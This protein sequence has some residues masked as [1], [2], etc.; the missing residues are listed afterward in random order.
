[1]WR[2]IASR[3]AWGLA[4][5]VLLGSIPS[6]QGDEHEAGNADEAGFRRALA[7]WEGLG[8]PDLTGRPIVRLALRQFEAPPEGTDHVHRPRPRVEREFGFLLS[9]DDAEIRVLNFD[10]R[11]RTYPLA[12]FTDLEPIAL[13]TREP[14]VAWK[15]FRERWEVEWIAWDATTLYPQ[16]WYDPFKSDPIP[17]TVAFLMAHACSLEGDTQGALNLWR[18]NV[19]RLPHRNPEDDWTALARLRDEVLRLALD[20]WSESVARRSASW[21]SALTDLRMLKG[22]HGH[23][24]ARAP[25][26]VARVAE[27]ETTL[28]GMALEESTY[29]A[30]LA[31]ASPAPAQRA[32]RLLKAAPAGLWLR[33]DGT[34]AHWAP[35]HLEMG[36]GPGYRRED[37]PRIFR[38]LLDLGPPAYPALLAHLEDERIVRC[39]MQEDDDD[40]RYEDEPFEWRL[41]RVWELALAVLEASTGRHFEAYAE[42]GETAHDAVLRWW[43]LYQ[44]EG[45]RGVLIAGV[46]DAKR[47]SRH[48]AERL[49]ERYPEVALA[50]IRQVCAEKSPWVPRPYV[51]ALRVSRDPQA[52]A[53]LMEVVRTA[54]WG[55]RIAACRVLEARG[56]P[57]VWH[58]LLVD[59]PKIAGSNYWEQLEGGSSGGIEESFVYDLLIYA[60]GPLCLRARQMLP[61]TSAELQWALVDGAPL[62]MGYET[63]APHEQAPDHERS[64]VERDAIEAMLIAMIEAHDGTGR[65]AIRAAE[66]LAG[67]WPD[68]YEFDSRTARV[69]MREQAYE[70]VN[71]WRFENDRDELEVPSRPGY[72]DIAPAVAF[73]ILEAYVAADPGAMR[74]RLQAL[75]VEL[76]FDMLP[77]IHRQRRRSHTADQ[78]IG[79]L[80]ELATEVAS[81]VRELRWRE[82]APPP[83]DAVR[84][85]AAALVGKPVSGDGLMAIFR[86]FARGHDPSHAGVRCTLIREAEE[87][88]YVLELEMMPDELELPD[89]HDG[90][91][92]TTDSRVYLPESLIEDQLGDPESWWTRFRVRE[93]EHELLRRP[94][95][96]AVRFVC[97]LVR[98]KQG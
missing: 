76:G 16:R 51:R 85:R 80:D 41:D 70:I 71:A 74:K 10:L 25:S 1:M 47:I 54:A 44:A 48:R 72:I 18:E 86:A 24:L 67:F 31:D 89:K 33:Y 20:A 42:E 90:Y 60:P 12:Q 75:I 83:P 68:K 6:A 21:T 2:S 64:D 88:G 57:G 23:A 66:H 27:L 3:T 65:F 81:I 84:A 8:Y 69:G 35:W 77:F 46:L 19:R 82:S 43:D 49:I 9:Q 91:A 73:N 50:T 39:R 78:E 4:L 87:R 17:S 30:A 38:Q 32:E 37:P 79:A 96:G 29:A 11:L 26:L 95:S 28:E 93:L 97:S 55:A 56:R 14:L 59:W 40:E 5:V 15:A 36:I 92:V 13:S 7:W 22:Q 53:F 52:D 45:E 98:V 94:D 34:D 58:A 63:H 62:A 61:E